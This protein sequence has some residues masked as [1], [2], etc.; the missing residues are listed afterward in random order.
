MDETLLEIRNWHGQGYKPLIDFG[1]WRVA[2]LRYLE[3]LQ[4]DRIDS[5]ERHVETDEV[6]VL[7]Q[8]R[9][10]LMIG[11]RGAKID[12]IRAQVMQTGEIYNVKRSVWH[13]ILLTRDASVLIVENADTGKAN[14]EFD[15]LAPELRRLIVETAGVEQMT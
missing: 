7:V 4:A 9:G 3:A 1:Q 15:V 11:G 8:G 10:I 5:M 6:F 14:T 2:I 12:G 13:T